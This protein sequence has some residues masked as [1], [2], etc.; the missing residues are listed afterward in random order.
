M[1]KAGG[2]DNS[3]RFFLVYVR[4]SVCLS[5]RF[6]FLFLVDDI[7]SIFQEKGT[8]QI[9]SCLINNIENVTVEQCHQFLSKMEAIVFSDFRLV[10]KF[11]EKCRRSVCVYRIRI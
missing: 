4:L 11:V 9:I 6:G 8:G 10:N 7:L 5:L 3:D 2:G 1:P